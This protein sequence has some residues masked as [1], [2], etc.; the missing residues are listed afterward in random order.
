LA[1]VFEATKLSGWTC[2]G[3]AG[4]FSRRLAKRYGFKP[5]VDVLLEGPHGRRVAVEFEVSRADP[6]AN[7][8]KFLLAHQAGELGPEDVLVSMFSPAIARGRRCIAGVFARHLRG[9]GVAAFQVSLLPQL[10]P[11]DIQ[12]L[13]QAVP[14]ALGA[15]LLPV[16]KEIERVISVVEPKG[17]KEHRIHF[18]GDVTDVIANVWAW[19][20]EIVDPAH[21]EL[22]GNRRRIQ[23][24]VHDPVGGE[25]APSKFCSFIPASKPGGPPLPPS[26]TMTIPIYASLGEKDPRFDGNR[27]RN[28][29]VD[30][31][32]FESFAVVGSALERTFERWS[33]RHAARV[34]LREPVSILAPPPWFSPRT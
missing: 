18:A 27:A 11:S 34:G 10:D 9:E 13:N 12:R 31:L 6:V 33:E 22:W 14:E 23:F 19:N 4:L 16:K 24:F 20:D 1:A 2:H 26:G 32:A 5:A 25:F 3:E 30:K 8:V 17:E 29:L 7:Q 21:G 15:E 28:H